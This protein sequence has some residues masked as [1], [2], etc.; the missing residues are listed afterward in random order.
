MCDMV[1]DLNALS[2][3]FG[4][5]APRYL[6]NTLTRLEQPQRDGLVIIEAQRITVTPLGRLLLR[7]LALAFNGRLPQPSG[8]ADSR[9]A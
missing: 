1:L 9:T 4:I 7:Q 5:D 8:I 6:A 3:S 2:E